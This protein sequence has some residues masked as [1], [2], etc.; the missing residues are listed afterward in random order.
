M[1]HPIVRMTMSLRPFPIVV[2]LDG[3]EYSEIVLEHAFDQAARHDTAEL[4]FLRV[5]DSKTQDLQPAEDWLTRI[6]IEGME[7][8]CDS[9][10]CPTRV[11]V[12]RGKPE[13]EITNFAAELNAGMIVI[14]RYGLHRTSVADLV[15]RNTAIPTLI[16][17]LSGREVDV[18]PQCADCVAVRRESDG[19]RWFCAAHAGDRMR[20]STLVPPIT[21]SRGTI[22]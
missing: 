20:L 14:G 8:F 15:L 11:I 13:E 19:E 22:Y 4:H 6:V 10:R 3:S 7:T 16:V 1:Q 21:A 17:G 9:R 18:E 5:I 2:A 12:R